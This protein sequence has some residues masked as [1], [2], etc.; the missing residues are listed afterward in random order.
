[1]WIFAAKLP[2]SDLNSAVDFQGKRPENSTKKSPA[3]FTQDFG[4]INSPRISAEALL[5]NII[6]QLSSIHVTFDGQIFFRFEAPTVRHDTNWLKISVFR[7]KG[8]AVGA[9][10]RFKERWTGWGSSSRKGILNAQAQTPIEVASF[11]NSICSS[12]K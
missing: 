9:E 12:W 2:N 1:M 10:G 11:Q 6:Y 7:C 4:Q 8:D 5:D 3:K